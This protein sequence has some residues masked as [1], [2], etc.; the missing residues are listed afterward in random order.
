MAMKGI[1]PRYIVVV[2]MLSGVK[3]TR[4]GE[5]GQTEYQEIEYY[6]SKVAFRNRIKF[7]LF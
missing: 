7:Y 4:L 6:F 2:E 5:F 3:V 1:T